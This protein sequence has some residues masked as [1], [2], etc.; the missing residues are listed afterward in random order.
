MT[1]LNGE[2]RRS[3]VVM[4]WHH[5]AAGSSALVIVVSSPCRLDAGLTVM[6][7]PANLENLITEYGSAPPCCASL[8][9]LVAA[10]VV[11]CLCRRCDLPQ[12]LDGRRSQEW[13][14]YIVTHQSYK[15]HGRGCRN[16]EMLTSRTCWRIR[17]I[18]LTQGILVTDWRGMRDWIRVSKR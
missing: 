15:K 3:L 16:P 13:K 2:A 12:S 6:C 14:Q 9:D 1:S 11:I 18:G 8:A 10:G 4:L 5:R 7:N 17:L